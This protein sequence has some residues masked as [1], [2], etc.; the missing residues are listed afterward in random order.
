MQILK[1]QKVI[2]VM[3]SISEKSV[4]NQQIQL[5]RAFVVVLLWYCTPWC[6]NMIILWNYSWGFNKTSESKP[7]FKTCEAEHEINMDV[8]K[9]AFMKSEQSYLE[10]IPILRKRKISMHYMRPKVCGHLPIIPICACW[11]SHLKQSPC[12]HVIDII[13]SSFLLDFGAWLRGIVSIQ[14]QEH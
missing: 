11:V 14:P 5:R 7:S 13:T 9:M 10:H 8:I 6:Q 2:S 1:R 3:F 12:I 4:F